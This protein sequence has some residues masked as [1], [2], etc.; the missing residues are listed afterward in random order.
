MPNV[1]DSSGTIGTTYL[2]TCLSRQSLPSRRTN[3]IVVRHFLVLT[4]AEKLFVFLERGT[5][6]V[7]ML[8]GATGKRA[9]ERSRRSRRYFISTLFSGGL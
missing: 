8:R 1:R 3:A 9:A 2:P 5:S 6:R 7:R 4:A